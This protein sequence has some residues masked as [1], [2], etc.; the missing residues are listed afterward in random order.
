MEI[1][2]FSLDSRAFKTKA[3]ALNNKLFFASVSKL[4]FASAS[5][6]LYYFFPTSNINDCEEF[7]FSPN[8]SAVYNQACPEIQQFSPFL[9]AL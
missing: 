4:F 6:F 5:K 1:C 3:R 7:H 8:K 9:T 2:I